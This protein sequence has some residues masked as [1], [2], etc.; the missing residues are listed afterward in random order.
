[1]CEYARLPAQF[2]LPKP[3]AVKTTEAAGITLAG[4]TAI[5]ALFHDLKLEPG[6]SLFINGGSTAVGIYAIQLAKAHG[7]T[8]TVTGSEKKEGFLRSLGVD[9]VS[10]T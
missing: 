7:C 1:M 8:V 9:H 5:H 3:T 10:N 4:V 6:Q 2:V